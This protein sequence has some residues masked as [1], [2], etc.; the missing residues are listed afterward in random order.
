[1]PN[2]EIL[3]N[4]LPVFLINVFQRYVVYFSFENSPHLNDWD[5]IEVEG[6]AAQIDVIAPSI[7]HY[8]KVQAVN[9]LGYGIISD[10]VS[11]LAD[12]S[13]GPGHPGWV[14]KKFQ[15]RPWSCSSKWSGATRERWSRMRSSDSSAVERLAPVYFQIF[16]VGPPNTEDLPFLAG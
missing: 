4:L 15:T 16:F 5:R 6:K 12:E 2:G 14:N 13:C 10:S 9:D 7:P 1:M 8:V 3:V 11:S